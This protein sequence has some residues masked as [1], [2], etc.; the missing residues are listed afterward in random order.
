M[1][2]TRTFRVFVSSTFT[3]PVCRV[4]HPL[5]ETWLGQV[6]DCPA[7]CG[8]RL[9]IV[10]PSALRA[11]HALHLSSPRPEPEAPI[12]V[13]QG[14]TEGVWAVAFSPD[15]TRIVS[16][17]GD[18]T[19]KIWDAD[20]GQNLATLSGHEQGVNALAYSPDGT[21]IV[22]G[23]EDKTLKIWDAASGKRLA[24]LSGH[25]YGVNAVAYSPDG[26]RIVSASGKYSE[27]HIREEDN[28]LMVWDATTG[29][30]LATLPGH[31]NVVRAVAYS[32]DGARI[33]SGSD[34]WTVRVWDAADGTQLA[35]FLGHKDAVRT[36]AFSPDCSRILSGS[37]DGRIKVWEA[38]TFTES[39]TFRHAPDGVEIATLS[40]H[41]G[42][43]NTVAYSP[44]GARILSGSSDHTMR[45]WDAA[46][47][48]EP[49]SLSHH[50]PDVPQ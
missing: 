25:K 22:S 15:G 5:D 21:R 36:V 29:K 6:I 7:G 42:G 11:G 19:L 3:C 35:D 14:H 39:H 49:A 37:A 43:V 26:T 40:G 16:G 12:R 28:A 27:Q 18:K 4:E 30:R 1:A 46:A 44:D 50:T 24:T 10:E 20:S 38:D 13:L 9:E 45:I 17:S 31:R 34:D 47:S 48:A 32:P 33:I 23:S 8:T 2:Q 41:A